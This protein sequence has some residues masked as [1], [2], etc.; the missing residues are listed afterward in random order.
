M[1]PSG[2]PDPAR[3]ESAT[4]E[5]TEPERT[6][7]ARTEAARTELGRLAPHLRV[8][9]RDR[10]GGVQIVQAAFA[11]GR[12]DDDE[13]DQRMRA[14]LTARTAADLEK[15][16]ADLPETVTS[17]VSR[18]PASARA[19]GRFAIAFK[20]SIRRGGRWRVPA[21]PTSGIYKGKG[22]LGL[23]GAG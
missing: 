16:T 22:R 20:S 8:S 10:D 4:P 7:P 15:L 19:P 5:R 17:P 18:A 21:R 6:E 2:Q 11:E 9:D 14:A 1:Q 23:R 13:F 12:L 3:S